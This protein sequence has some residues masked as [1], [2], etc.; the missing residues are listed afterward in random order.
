MRSATSPLTDARRL[1]WDEAADEYDRYFV[2]RFAPWTEVAVQ[3][4]RGQLP[5][6]PILVPC[7]GPFP[8]L[9]S[10]ARNHPG[11]PL[12]GIDLSAGML[13]A[14]RERVAKVPSARTVEGDATRLRERWPGT[15]AAV[16]SVFGLQQLPDPAAALSDWV[17][18]LRPRGRLSVM[19]WPDQVEASGPF[20][21]LE[22][23]VTEHRQPTAV[24]ASSLSDTLTAAGATIDAD[25]SPCFPV[26]HPDA[27]AFWNAMVTGG[28]LRALT[29]ARGPQFTDDLRRTFLAQ[30]PTGP[31][32]HE[33]HARWLLAT[34]EGDT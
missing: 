14:A 1:A 7:C 3:G 9:P 19:Y 5:P 16:V 32:R 21:L 34:L 25:E 29:T 27:A 33:P 13:R 17:G 22:R 8:E 30:A 23:L 18:T 28:P 11:R 31:W 4:L 24:P 20:A 26:S 15:A 2:P 10:L 12:V 6:G